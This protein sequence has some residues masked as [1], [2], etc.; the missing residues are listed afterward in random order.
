MRVLLQVDHE[1]VTS[2]GASDK[3]GMFQV[4]EVLNKRLPGDKQYRR[5]GF[6]VPPEE[7]DKVLA[8]VDACKTMEEIAVLMAELAVR[9]PVVENEGISE[10]TQ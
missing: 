4:K 7:A 3:E 6:I 10:L 9:Y 1:A 5:L 2:H 8:E